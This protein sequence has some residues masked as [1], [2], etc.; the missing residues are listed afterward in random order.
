[1]GEAD[2]RA[3]YFDDELTRGKSLKQILYAEKIRED[4][5]RAL[6]P[7]F[8]RWDWDIGMNPRRPKPFLLAAGLPIERRQ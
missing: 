4:R 2:G 8:S 7:G 5:I 6:G 3:K 1:V